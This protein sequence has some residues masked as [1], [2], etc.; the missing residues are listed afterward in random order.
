MNL[1]DNSSQKFTIYIEFKL[2]KVI[3]PKRRKSRKVQLLLRNKECTGN[4]ICSLIWI[5]FLIQL[6]VIESLMISKL[7]VYLSKTAFKEFKWKNHQLNNKLTKSWN[8]K[9]K[10]KIRI[11]KNWLLLKW[12]AKKI[13]RNQLVPSQLFSKKIT[14]VLKHSKKTWASLLITLENWLLTLSTV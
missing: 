6:K 9:I 12:P 14:P 8:K 11:I 10:I 13:S 2:R 1:V 3:L 5:K 4:L 7:E